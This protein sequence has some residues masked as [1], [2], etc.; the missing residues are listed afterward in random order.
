MLINSSTSP[1]IHAVFESLFAVD[2]CGPVGTTIYNQIPAF[3]PQI[4]ST[5]TE[6]LAPILLVMTKDVADTIICQVIIGQK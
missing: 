4:L 6:F 5:A 3:P 2:Q 1:S